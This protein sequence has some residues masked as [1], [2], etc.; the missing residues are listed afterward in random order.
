MPRR[1]ET[2]PTWLFLTLG[3]GVAGCAAAGVWFWLNSTTGSAQPVSVLSETVVPER[4]APSET[5]LTET[6]SVTKSSPGSAGADS[7][8]VN[9]NSDPVEPERM[10]A[11]PTISAVD[12]PAIG[13][14]LHDPSV[15][16]RRSAARAL[17]ALGLDAAGATRDLENALKD[18][19]TETRIWAALAL[20]QIDSNDQASVPV[21][22]QG[23][24]HESP[25]V[26]EASA[27][28]VS[29]IQFQ[30]DESAPVIEML[31]RLSVE[32]PDEA[33]RRAASSASKLLNAKVSLNRDK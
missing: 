6:S 26:R 30:G 9:P 28:T 5:K 19:D 7:D 10:T 13:A 31:I 24:K 15:N 16:I 14:M 12:A 33:V 18:D 11:K 2:M 25:E 21:L 32:D 4:S 23:L 8:A 22:I 1:R 3:I 20:A 29:M 17:H 27:L